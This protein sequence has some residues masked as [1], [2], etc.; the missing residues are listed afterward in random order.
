MRFA[1]LE[2]PRDRF[3]IQLLDDSTD[4]TVGVAEEIVQR[5]ARGFAGL[6]G[7]RLCICTGRIGM[8]IRRAR[9]MKG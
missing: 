6:E 8:G 5:Y 7:S 2:Y 9:W 3:E 1:G 4:E